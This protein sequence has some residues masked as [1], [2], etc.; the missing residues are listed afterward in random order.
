MRANPISVQFADC[1]Q[2]ALTGTEAGDT[3]VAVEVTLTNGR[4]DLLIAADMDG[5]RTTL[6]QPD[7]N[8]TTD[9][10]FCVIRRDTVGAIVHVFFHGGSYAQCGDRRVALAAG[11]S[12][13]E[14]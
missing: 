11:S 1:P 13:I 14:S 8:C 3:H 4:V 12:W 6:T 9:A 2:Q 7:W 5:E 10:D